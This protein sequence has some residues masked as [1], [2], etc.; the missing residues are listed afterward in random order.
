M[1][2]TIDENAAFTLNGEKRTFSTKGSAPFKYG[3]NEVLSTVSTDI[4]FNQPWYDQGYAALD[5]LDDEEFITLKNGITQ[6]MAAI[7]RQE[8]SVATEDFTL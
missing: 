6:S 7:V 2:Q 1:P 4:T 5:F 8:C 3:E